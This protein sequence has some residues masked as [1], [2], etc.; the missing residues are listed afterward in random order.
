MYR[1]LIAEDET[2]MRNLLVRYIGRKNAEME[3][4][5][6]AVNGEEALRLAREL[7]PD[8]VITDIFMPVMNGLE[9]LKAANEE[10]MPLK[11]IIIS[12][13]DTFEY[14]KQAISLGVS[15]YLLK[16]FDPSELDQ[17]LDKILSELNSQKMLRENMQILQAKINEKELVFREKILR[18]MMI[19]KNVSDRD[20]RNIF[21]DSHFY[22]VCLL[23][24]PM[25]MTSEKWNM[26]NQKNIE[27]LIS[28]LKGNYV[29]KELIIYGLNF[30][31]NGV[32]CAVAGNAVEQQ[33]FLQKIKRGLN[34]LQNSM[35][36]YYHI[37]LICVIGKIC[38]TW[39]LLSESYES[40]L[41]IWRQID[42]EKQALLVW[43]EEDKN[44]TYAE[45]VKGTEKI[46]RLKEEILF[47][48]KTGRKEAY[49]EDFEKLISLYAAVSPR[50]IDFVILSVEELCYTLYEDIEKSQKNTNE[51]IKL[52]GLQKQL[53]SRLESASLLEIKVVLKEY[54]E[55]CGEWYCKV[56]D[57][58]QKT[59]ITEQVKKL[60]ETNL[61]N[62]ELTLE[63]IAEQIHFSPTYIR[64]MFRQETGEKIAEYIIGKRMEK[65]A[66]LLLKTDM[67]ILDIAYNCGY[68]NQRYF[69][70]SFKKYYECTPTDFKKM[71]EE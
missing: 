33:R 10:K 67:K 63:W 50:K 65:A 42:S 69:A 61:A 4:V 45:D 68:S 2:E 28:V 41:S 59:Q 47:E 58:Q 49:L 25:Y 64:Q 1:I 22:T 17:V 8:I 7:K 57:F 29:P 40:A 52:E 56:K 70:S 23:K 34:H 18:D 20:G 46:R 60:I 43:G 51:I 66:R 48:I 36:K 54:L 31:K 13:Y 55:T 35:Q 15:D 21:G 32:I 14:A 24:L 5:G 26:E 11:A 30:Q 44:E 19:G 3:V 6:N 27:E 9:F 16:P 38:E 12:G 53:K 39:R 71:M 62:E 37:P